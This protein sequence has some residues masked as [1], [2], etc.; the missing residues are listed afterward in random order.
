M[1]IW[2]FLAR[3]PQADNGSFSSQ[4]SS[5]PSQHDGRALG[6]ELILS[7]QTFC[8]KTNKST[9]HNDVIKVITT[10]ITDYVEIN[11]KNIISKKEIGRI[12]FVKQS[13][14]I[15]WRFCTLLLCCLYLETKFVGELSVLG[16]SSTKLYKENNR[17]TA[18]LQ[19]D[20]RIQPLIISLLSRHN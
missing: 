20:C 2:R 4:G 11:R 19:L 5:P 6:I 16:R 14:H 9:L 12:A 10:L 8:S 17:W 13:R 3:E 15:V 7:N 18:D 1:I